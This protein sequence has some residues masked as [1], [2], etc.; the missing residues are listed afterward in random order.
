MLGIFRQRQRGHALGHVAKG[1][2][3]RRLQRA[4]LQYFK[5]E[6]RALVMAFKYPAQQAVTKLKSVIFS[7]GRTGVITPVADLEPVRCAGVTISSATLHNFDEVM[8][9]GL[10]SGDNVL[11]ER[12]GEVIPK[13][14]KVIESARTGNETE[15]KPPE[16]WRNQSGPHK[17]FLAFCIHKEPRREA[18]VFMYRQATATYFRSH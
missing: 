11:V 6:N 9:L 12:A 3:E 2:T 15:V 7:V 14:V 1:E 13:I 17:L 4:L 18:G 16:T 10:K 5:P 8:R